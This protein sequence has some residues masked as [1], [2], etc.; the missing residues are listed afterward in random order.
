MSGVQRK[1]VKRECNA[2]E[3][4]DAKAKVFAGRVAQDSKNGE[5][6][7]TEQE[8]GQVTGGAKITF[9]QE[10]SSGGA[11]VS[12]LLSTMMNAVKPK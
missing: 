9:I 8:L 11:F 10:A 2:Q 3:N 5:I 4:A 6:E 7:L 12:E 1:S